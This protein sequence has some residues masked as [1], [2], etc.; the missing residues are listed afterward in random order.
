M[1]SSSTPCGTRRTLRNELM[2]YKLADSHLF[3]TK[4]GV[5]FKTSSTKY[6]IITEIRAR[7]GIKD[8]EEKLAK[9]CK[10]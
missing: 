4:A 9:Y 3:I 8:G 5:I 7:V 6:C 1:T 10:T 2:A